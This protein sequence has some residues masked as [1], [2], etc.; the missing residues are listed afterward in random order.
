[1]DNGVVFARLRQRALEGRPGRMAYF[2]WSAAYE[3]N[4]VVW[5]TPGDV[6]PAIMVD[7]EVIARANPALG[8]RIDLEHVAETERNAMDHVTFCVERLGVG[9][10]PVTVDAPAHDI[11]LAAWNALADPESKRVG[12]VCFFFDVTPD[13]RYASIA[14]GGRRGDDRQHVEIVDHAEGTGWLVDRLAE[15]DERHEPESI[16]CDGRNPAA[17]EFV[18]K[19]ALRGVHVGELD[20]NEHAQACSGL[21]SAVSAG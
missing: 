2:G 4:T 3:D 11:D 10:W 8:I 5:D 16:E 1:M 6:P 14:V 12:A 9:D 19:L 18:D 15:L 20:T 17:A 13:G 21:A 7:P